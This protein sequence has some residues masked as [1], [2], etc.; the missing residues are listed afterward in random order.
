MLHITWRINNIDRLCKS[1]NA[2]ELKT[3]IEEHSWFFCRPSLMSEFKV[4]KDRKGDSPE[5]Y[6][7]LK[8][9]AVKHSL[10]AG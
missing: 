8:D 4:Y 10:L 6:M 2:E 3:W 9:F 5:I 1:G 7:S